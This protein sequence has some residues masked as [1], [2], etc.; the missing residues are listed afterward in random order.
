MFPMISNVQ[1][2]RA[3]KSILAR[4]KVELLNDHILFNADIKVGIMIEV[5]SAAVTADILANEVD[6]FSIG[7]NDLCQYT[8]AVDRMNEKISHLY[9]PFN[10]GVLRLI[11]NVIEQGR[12]HNIHVGLCGEMA[13][14][15]LTT[16][17]LLGMGL[18]DFSVSAASIPT[19]KNIIINN[20][21]AKAKN[22]YK[23][24]MKMDSSE[25]IT[26]YLQ[27]AIQ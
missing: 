13:S 14:D 3:A 25:K 7:T 22:I 4:A 17:L 21:S 1:E 5:P 23:N 9:D 26:T 24:V 19:I 6:F 2:I 11:N 10:P 12:K 16:L 15:P 18:E 8:L 20:S 27:E